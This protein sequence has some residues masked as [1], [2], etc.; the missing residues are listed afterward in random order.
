MVK[1]KKNPLLQGSLDLLVLQTLNGHSMHGYAISRHLK[2]VSSD[3]LQVEEGSLYP[4]LHRLE[5][6]GL[7]KSRWGSSESN[8]R[9]KFY[10]LTR[11]GVKQLR[12]E[13]KSWHNMSHA[14]EQVLN[15]QS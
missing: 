7:I 14:I 15:F 10:E 13:K 6:R 12:S 5:R 4:A 9:A 11:E 8:R 3:F 1:P 2:D